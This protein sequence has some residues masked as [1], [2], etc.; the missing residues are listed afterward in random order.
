[1]QAEA[2]SRSEF[3]TALKAL[4]LEGKPGAFRARAPVPAAIEDRLEQLGFVENLT[5]L[6]DLHEAIRADG[7]SPERLGALVR[8]YINLGVNSEFHWHPAHA[9]FK[10]RALLYAQRLV[11]REPDSP[12]GLWHRAFAKALIGLP[13]D[14]R[15]DLEEAGKRVGARKTGPAIP[16]PDW[17][18]LLE[19]YLAGDAEKLRG[20][21]G[22]HQRLAA[23]LRMMV[24]EYPSWTTL[25]LQ[26]AKDVVAA[27]PECYLA[28]ELMCQ[29][30][31]VANLHVATE[32]GPEVLSRLL[33]AKLDA[34]RSLPASVRKV[35][36]REEFDEPAAL[37]ALADAGRP[38]QDGGEPSWGA[39]AHLVRETRFVQV[40]RRLDFLRNKLSVPVDDYW[41]EAKTLIAGHRYSRY[42]ES[43]SLPP[44]EAIRSLTE[45]AG[46]IDTANFE[47]T[48]FHI[49]SNLSTLDPP[50]AARLRRFAMSHVDATVRDESRAIDTANRGDDIARHARTLLGIDPRSAFAM[51]SLVYADWDAVKDQVPAW[52]K[53]VGEAPPLLY[54]LG[55]KYSALKQY[56]KAAKALAS[57]IKQSPD[58]AAYELLAANFKAVGD[59]KRWKETLDDFLDKVEDHGLDHARIRVQ[60]AND[61]MEHQQWAEAR[62]YAE[63]AAETWAGWAMLC[64]AVLRGAERLGE[65]RAL[66]PPHDRALSGLELDR[67]VSLLQADRPR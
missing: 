31:G 52:E 32:L 60:I 2:F 49:A 55:K 45:V 27:D 67:L 11:A 56:E 62:P 29:V 22:P 41:N 33:P 18:G 23:L 50:R 13:R 47:N 17:L 5:A 65:R 48:A 1:M 16:P 53:L 57:Y 10:A 26:A 59:R 58:S 51:G 34:V 7:E 43:F 44:Q 6:R 66:D 9:A 42:L 4:G 61:F 25:A 28:H 36:E 3:L 54:P 63:A 35:L 14:A 40:F 12:R 19:A 24:V 21:A 37:A 39:L 46:K 20:H 8:G 64:R 38:V 15:A 30:G